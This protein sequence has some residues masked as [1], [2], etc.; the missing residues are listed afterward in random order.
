[1]EKRLH[2]IVSGRVQLVMYRDFARR[3]AQKL[4]IVG[5]VKNLKDNTVEVVAEGRK[6]RLLEYIELLKEGP[7]LSEVKGVDIKWWDGVT[8]E[9]K[10][11][12]IIHE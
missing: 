7:F 3:K 8:G 9:F 1:M 4:G 5:W 10:V 12:E 11:F 2:A 6:E